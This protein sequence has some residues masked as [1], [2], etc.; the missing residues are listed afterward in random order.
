MNELKNNLE[1]T[2][3]ELRANSFI[4]SL[5]YSRAAIFYPANR[6]TKGMEKKLIEVAESGGT[7]PENPLG[8]TVIKSYGKRLEVNLHGDYLLQPH[9]DVLE[10]VLAFADTIQLSEESYK[11]GASIKWKDVYATIPNGS[12]ANARDD[13]FDIISDSSSVVLSIGLYKLSKK[14]GYSNPADSYLLIERRLMQLTSAFLYVY[15]LNESDSRINKRLVRF[16]EDIRFYHDPSKVTRADASKDKTNHLFLVVD[17]RLLAAIRD[18]GY[19]YR[20]DHHKMAKYR[21]P[22]LRSFIM[23]MRTHKP[24]F[25]HGKE[26]DWLIKLYINSI[27]VSISNPRKMLAA[28]RNHVIKNANDV[29]T[30]FGVYIKKNELGE[31]KMYALNNSMNEL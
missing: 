7:N 5:L 14:L 25:L 1:V 29:A 28:I 11:A 9:K 31:W 19:A 4:S 18:F 13:E 8:S 10:A 21:T 27:P 6:L 15:E 2:I 24:K 23:F 12:K 3:Q 20:L 17:K 16:V 30:D 22:S 26:L